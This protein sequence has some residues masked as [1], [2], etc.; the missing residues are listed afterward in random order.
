MGTRILAWAT[1]GNAAAPSESE[2]AA[3][4][5]TGHVS[6]TSA[7]DPPRR[8]RSP[9]TGLASVRAPPSTAPGPLSGPV[10]PEPGGPSG[11]SRRRRKSSATPRVAMAANIIAIIPTRARAARNGP[12][13]R[14]CPPRI[15]PGFSSRVITGSEPP[16]L[17]QEFDLAPDL[18]SVPGA[19][20]ARQTFLVLGQSLRLVL[21]L[22]QVDVT[23]PLARHRG[24]TVLRQRIGN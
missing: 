5:A 15:A 7:N 2:S 14:R 8:E 13:G 16:L 9:P 11:F 21:E 12:R 10:R 24:Q 3:T 18:G 17:P 22:N 1:A 23:S 6:I 19:R 4:T 20:V